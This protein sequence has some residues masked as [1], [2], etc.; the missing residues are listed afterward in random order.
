MM[1]INCGCARVDPAPSNS[2]AWLNFIVNALLCP[3][4]LCYPCMSIK[5]YLGSPLPCEESFD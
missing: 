3:E 2:A 1:I 5:F 4:V